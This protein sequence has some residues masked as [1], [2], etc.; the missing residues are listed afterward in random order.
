MKK[1][2]LL[3]LMTVI[4]TGT[5]FI[6]TGCAFNSG[7]TEAFEYTEGNV[8]LSVSYIK[9]SAYKRVTDEEGKKYRFETNMAPDMQLVGDKGFIEFSF[10]T[11]T[12]ND[13]NYAGYKEEIKNSMNNT[14]FK[15]LKINDRDA[16]YREV[17]TSG[18]VFLAID[19]TDIEYTTNPSN[20][21]FL[22]I[23]IGGI[24]PEVTRGVDAYNEPD[25]QAIINSITLEKLDPD[26]RIES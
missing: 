5:L 11:F 16:F 14:G 10:E 21:L 15:E 13:K 8:K 26:K 3:I 23:V 7:S 17:G 24:D 25:V 12:N 6:L 9:G 22:R 4:V 20:M 1:A 19:M 2:I 18:Y